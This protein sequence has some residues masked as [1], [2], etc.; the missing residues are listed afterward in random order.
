MDP[1]LENLPTDYD[2]GLD[3]T[4]TKTSK[5]GYSDYN[6]SKWARKETSL[7]TAEQAA[8][9]NYGLFDLSSFLPK[10]PG[11]VELKV[12][13]EMFEASV[14]GEEYD[15]DRWGQ[16]FKPSGMNI[17][18]SA[19]PASDVDAAEASF[20][21]PVETKASAPIESST[22]PWEDDAN[23][24]AEAPVVAPSGAS[25]TSSQR[26]EDILAMIRNRQK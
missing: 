23:E 1:E 10:K 21:A 2:A 22:A 14:N 5:G 3:F 20:K 11:D 24:A 26:A 15:P 7:T 19:V 4:V 8:I 9:D 13:K 25:K 6:T 18:N 12:I 16:Y 17:G